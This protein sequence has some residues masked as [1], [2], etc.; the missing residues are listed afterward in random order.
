MHDVEVGAPAGRRAADAIEMFGGELAHARRS[1]RDRVA[2][3]SRHATGEEDDGGRALRE[4]QQAEKSG[5]GLEHPAGAAGHVGT[6]L[7]PRLL[8]GERADEALDAD[9]IGGER[10]L[11]AAE[12]HRHDQ[13]A[14]ARG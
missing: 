6:G 5:G 12:R 14:I 2:P 7:V 4:F 10:D 11:D 3:R 9:V 13:D 8:A 1:R